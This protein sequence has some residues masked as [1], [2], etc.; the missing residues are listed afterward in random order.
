ML[1]QYCN[2][3]LFG[4]TGVWSALVGDPRDSSG[5]GKRSSASNQSERAA[6]VAWGTVAFLGM[7]MYRVHIY[8]DES[9]GRTCGGLRGGTG[10]GALE[11]G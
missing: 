5:Q 1:L 8:Y 11:L 4:V 2:F 3:S 9:L 7:F 6:P 10:A